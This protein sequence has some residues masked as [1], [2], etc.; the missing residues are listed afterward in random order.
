[1]PFSHVHPRFV[2]GWSRK[3][4]SGEIGCHLQTVGKWGSR[5][6]RRLIEAPE[7]SM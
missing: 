7:E 2:N 5:T 6:S 4:R 3:L 1:M